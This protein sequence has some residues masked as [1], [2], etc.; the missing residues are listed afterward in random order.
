MELVVICSV[1]DPNH[2]DSDPDPACHFDAD[3]NPACHFDANPDPACHFDA[4]PDPIIYCE[5]DPN[6]ES[7]FKIQAQNLEKVLK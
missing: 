5:A 2:S 4:D 1:A 7:R 3:P 6:P